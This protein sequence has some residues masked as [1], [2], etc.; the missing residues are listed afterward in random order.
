MI[1]RREH[2]YCNLHL[3]YLEETYGLDRNPGLRNL[4][5][6]LLTNPNTQQNPKR[7]LTMNN[8]E[9]Q[10][11]SEP[12]NTNPSMILHRATRKTPA[13]ITE[14]IHGRWL[15]VFVLPRPTKSVY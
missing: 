7:N 8:I 3:K 13:R 10:N 6:K 15:Q 11:A 12:L 14:Y 5:H 9:H 4:F 2:V 1:T